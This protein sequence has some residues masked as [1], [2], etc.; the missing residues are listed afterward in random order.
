[1]LKKNQVYSIK[2]GLAIVM[3]AVALIFATEAAK[4]VELS[5]IF[6]EA[7]EIQEPFEIHN[8]IDFRDSEP[9]V[10]WMESIEISQTNS[11]PLEIG[12]TIGIQ[13][14]IEVKELPT[15]IVVHIF[16]EDMTDFFVSDEKSSFKQLSNDLDRVP[17]LQYGD[18]FN[19]HF[20]ENDIG[21]GQETSS[22]NGFESIE[23]KKP[24]TYF[25]SV[26]VKTNKNIIDHYKSKTSVLEITDPNEIWMK[27][28]L[29]NL[30]DVAE[31]QKA[32]TILSIG[33]AYYGIAISIF[34]SGITLL[35]GGFKKD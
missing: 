35:I 1:M 4:Q 29:E 22:L 23:F 3:F 9:W 16:H 25:A 5:N 6:R 19:I 21:E 14:L 18:M 10:E 13:A 12:E 20:L 11:K 31:E 7:Y 15:E 33:V 32:D 28:T 30:I 17:G 24:G 27:S 8:E 2:I 34:F 26:S